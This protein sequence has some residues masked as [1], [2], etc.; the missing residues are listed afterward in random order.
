[1]RRAVTCLEVTIFAWRPLVQPTNSRRE[2]HHVSVSGRIALVAL[3]GDPCIR[4]FRS[5]PSLL[6]V[7]LG[8]NPRRSRDIARSVGLR[9]PHGSCRAVIVARHR[10]RRGP[11]RSLACAGV[12][13][14]R[15]HAGRLAQPFRLRRGS[16]ALESVQ[17]LVLRPAYRMSS[18]PRWSAHGGEGRA[19]VFGPLRVVV[20]GPSDFDTPSLFIGGDVQ[21]AAIAACG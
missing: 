21:P 5:S 13:H 7:C 4:S 8:D 16:L 10:V 9:G 1:M 17:G 18:A 19:S 6:C 3:E 12:K 14:G 15:E 2:G 20:T 11:G